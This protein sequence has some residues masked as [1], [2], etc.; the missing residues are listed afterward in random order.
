MLLVLLG[1][2]T[3]AALVAPFLDR[4]LGR[5]AGWVLAAGFAVLLV[6][7]LAAGSRIMD[8]ETLEHVVAWMPEIGV[9]LQLR[10]DGTAW[11]FTVLVLGIGALVLAYAAKYFP[12]GRQTGFYFF[13]TAFAVSMQ[14]L[15]LAD[16]IIMMFVFWELT[17]ICSF[18]LIGITGTSATRPAVRTYIV[19]ALGGLALLAAVIMLVMRTGT[20]TL[21]T[22]LADPSWRQ[23]GTFL[24]TVVVLVIVAVFT[25]SAQ[26]PFHYWLPDA[27][28]ASTPVSTYLHAATMV[29][30]GIYLAMR[31]SPAFADVAV[32]NTV[33][34]TAGLFTAVI[35]AVFALQRTDLKELLA[36]STVSQ[37]GLIIA[38]IG[39]GT[40][41][42]LASAAVHTLAHAMFKAALFMLIGVIDHTAGTRDIRRL[43]GLR[44][45]M[46]VT[47]VL[48]TIAALS[49]AGIPP[50]FGFV[51]KEGLFTAFL[52]LPGSA[53]GLAVAAAVIASVGT[54]AYSFRIVHGAFGGPAGERG[55]REP[56]LFLLPPAVAAAGGFVAPFVLAGIDPLVSRTV[57][58]NLGVVHEPHLALWHGF[59]V[60]LLLS[61]VV[62]GVGLVLARG[63]RT[64]ERALSGR[65]FPVPGTVVFDFLH[66]AIVAFGRRIGD[67][68]RTHSLAPFLGTTVV[69]LI[70]F[71]VSQLIAQPDVPDHPAEV[72]HPVDWL[73]VGLLL[74][75][76]VASLAVRSRLA[77]LSL[78]GIAGFT[79]AMWFQ[80]IGGVDLVLT[81]LTVEILTVVVVVLVLRRLPHRFRPSTLRRKVTTGTIAIAAGLSATLAVYTLTGRRE[82][83][84]AS[85]YFMT[86]TLN[87]TGGSNVVNVILV[88]YR[89]LDTLGE[90]TV[91]GVAG[92]IMIAVI[93]TSGTAR[94]W[95]LP[96]IERYARN[97]VHVA[98]DNV[99]VMSTAARLLAPVILVW[100]VILLFTG[101]QRP[102]GG[103]VAALV[104]SAGA[105]LY[106]LTAPSDSRGKL[107]IPPVALIAAGIATGAGA[108]LLGFFQGSFLHPLHVE[109]P[110][111]WGGYDFTTALIF[112]IG[113]YLA[114]VGVLLA[115]LKELGQEPLPPA[116]TMEAAEPVDGAA[117]T[118]Q[119][120]GAGP[121]D[122]AGPGH[123]AMPSDQDDDAATVSG[124]SRVDEMA[125]ER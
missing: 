43:T 14:G 32:W 112:D 10:M 65:L 63:H 15:V 84:P 83:S 58:D 116:G 86:E 92:L 118:G 4:F 23:D 6:P 44:R 18:F 20:T 120:Q 122:G 46:P 87:E 42:A 73:L 119:D 98:R 27:M 24:T 68:T 34:V 72:T 93:R 9:E 95:R 11:L 62:I 53:G 64:V 1:G 70:G 100:S 60:P 85:D 80:L 16:D 74:V 39:V 107:R 121:D 21:S 66:G 69:V 38:V 25:K 91:L 45:A 109:I 40:P 115:A 106:F 89:A 71:T 56:L 33:L 77:A 99:I 48:T 101:H 79:V 59:N 111:P 17:T 13:I 76:V 52:E 37:L 67:L 75:S 29:K 12:P 7:V 22:I 82:R 30:A 55:S 26:F 102:G 41:G 51:S 50:L 57:L 3:A 97:V 94:F 31:F 104:G 103:F 123:G 124:D 8:G 35:G 36:Y 90:L 114:V 54:F 2:L 110:F 113:V 28:A 117:P 108:G 19:T 78:V 81:Q 49:M 96:S 61:A 47:A 105:A 5:A 125:G 88:D